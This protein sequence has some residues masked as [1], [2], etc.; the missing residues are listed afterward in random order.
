[1]EGKRL[2]EEITRLVI[3]AGMDLFNCVAPGWNERNYHRAM[4][5]ALSARGV[6]AESHLCGSL[7][8]R[9]RCA[10][11]FE[12]DIM[13]EGKVLLELKQ[14]RKNFAAAHSAQLINY[15]KLWNQDL[16]ILINSGLEGLRF[17]RGAIRREESCLH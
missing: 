7:M 15:L 11:R 10:D 5:K 2:H 4:L 17:K 9:G 16:G 6:F 8:H 12:L 13:V 14:I 3:G 1:V